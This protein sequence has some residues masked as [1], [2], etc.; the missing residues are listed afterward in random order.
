MNNENI[1]TH[2][3]RFFVKNKQLSLLLIIVSFVFGFLAFYNTSKQYDPEITL[4]AFRI[5]TSFPGATREE[6]E[7][8]VT[9]QIEDKLVEIPGIDKI[10]S[11][12]FDGGQSIVTVIFKIG[13]GLDASKTQVIEKMQSN[14]N[15]TPIGV[16]AP[17]IKQ[18]DPENVPVM[19]LLITGKDYTQ[20]GLR[21][22]AFDL[23][24]RLKVVPG[25]TNIEINGGKKRQLS[26][27]V[28]P[29]KLSGRGVS[30]LEV[31]QALEM[32][33]AR[34]STGLLEGEQYDVALLVEGSVTS[35]KDLTRI[36]VGGSAEFPVYLED[37]AKI[38]DGY[39]VTE[40]AIWFTKKN[41]KK[42]VRED[43][44]YLS[45][46]KAKGTNISNVTLSVEDEI[47]K[48]K[49][50]FVPEG[51]NLEITRNEG[52]TAHEEIMTLTE[53]LVLAVTIVTLTLM[54]FL[55]LRVALVVA[56]AIPLTL[57][58]VFIAGYLFDNSINRITLFALIF[59]L[60][61]LV[62]DAIVVVENIHRHF[63]KKDKSK[64]E[65]IAHATGE[66]GAGVLLST[67]TAVVVFAPMGLVTG[68]MGA[69]MGPIAFFAPVARLASLFVAYTLS[70]YL[71]SVFLDDKEHHG[72]EEKSY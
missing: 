61:L 29:V 26:V 51:I 47:K 34:L 3:A 64:D 30:I 11:Q 72:H 17:L 67:I 31:K 53:H 15:L 50:S 14:L 71:A 33:N 43:A 32:N 4:P 27:L 55:G 8:L 48:L 41:E 68:M 9:N 45:F 58:L 16:S 54:F 62:D 23:K 28:D 57:A 19:T 39:E 49:Q 56:T 66:V 21:E 40:K 46:A 6:V 20:E 38:D 12:S 69:Y 18:I 25:V 24:D 10:S 2:T 44:V 65:A 1:Y 7:K 13:S 52:A 59:S 5:V 36:I 35:G 60:G 37:V 22:F 63:Q 70:P 42:T